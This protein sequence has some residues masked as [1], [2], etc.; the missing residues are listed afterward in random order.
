MVT[1]IGV[2]SALAAEGAPDRKQELEV[3]HR[4]EPAYPDPEHAI[5]FD[6]R[7]LA[8]VFIE[9][10]GVPYRVEVDD[11]D[12]NVWD[13]AEPNVVW[14]RKLQSGAAT[15]VNRSAPRSRDRTDSRRTAV[16]PRVHFWATDGLLDPHATRAGAPTVTSK[17]VA[18]TRSQVRARRRSG[19]SGAG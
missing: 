11:A 19:R 9:T 13:A 18:N 2:F 12:E 3:R 8:T 15:K 1:W 14:R 6:V 10:D 17:G 7:C 16:R 4:E 5:P